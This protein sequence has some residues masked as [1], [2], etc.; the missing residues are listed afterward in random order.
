MRT[1][2]AYRRVI[3]L[4]TTLATLFSLYA[5]WM[6]TSGEGQWRGGSGAVGAL[7]VR[8]LGVTLKAPF[9]TASVVPSPRGDL[10]LTAAHCLG[11]VPASDITFAPFYHNGTA[12]FGNW[13]VT[14]Q[15]FAPHW[16]PGG[17][18][19]SDFAFLTVSG[20]VQALAGAERLAL[21]SPPPGRVTVEGYS[22]AGGATICTRKPATIEVE[23][24]RQLKFSCAG[25]TNG[26]SGGP[27]LTGI[28]KKSGL[29]T[30]V[31]VVGGYQQGGLS[32]DVSYS[33]PLT[34]AVIALYKK[35]S[36]ER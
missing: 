22:L 34:P 1:V 33:S 12:P 24:Q 15:V 31:G 35:L 26:A 17:D 25:Y 36:R 8:A 11:K 5:F 3:T 16:F 32:S 4:I 29:G 6:Q 20:N 2:W 9:C 14:S 23:H 21:S 30:I 18:P 27:F 7:F 19:N 10:L 13:R 28:S